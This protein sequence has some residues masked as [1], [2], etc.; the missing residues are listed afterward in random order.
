MIDLIFAFKDKVS[1]IESVFKVLIRKKN[2]PSFLG[3]FL[4]GIYSA[5]ASA[6]QR[7]FAQLNIQ[8][9]FFNFPI[10]ISEIILF[11][12]LIILFWQWKRDPPDFNKYYWLFFIFC[13]FFLGKAI[14]GYVTFG[15]LSFRNAALFYYTFFALLGYEFFKR[16]QPPSQTIITTILIILLGLKWIAGIHN[17][18]V[19]PYFCLCLILLFKIQERWIWL[20]VLPLILIRPEFENWGTTDSI[21]NAT[22]FFSGGGRARL[23]GH[24]LALVFLIFSLGEIL[25]NSKKKLKLPVIVVVLLVLFVVAF[26]IVDKNVVKS[27]TNF[28]EVAGGYQKLKKKIDNERAAFQQLTCPAR[29]Y[30]KEENSLEGEMANR[31]K[32][33]LPFVKNSEAEVIAVLKENVK[34]LKDKEA[35]EY[36][37]GLEKIEAERDKK[38]VELMEVATESDLAKLD[39][40]KVTEDSAPLKIKI[41][42]LR[43]KNNERLQNLSFTERDLESVIN[44]EK[45][46]KGPVQA[47]QS[48]LALDN[49]SV[50]EKKIKVEKNN[51]KP[52]SLTPQE[53]LNNLKKTIKKMDPDRKALVETKLETIQKE[54]FDNQQF[55]SEKKRKEALDEVDQLIK[56]VGKEGEVTI[57]KAWTLDEERANNQTSKL[58]GRDI[59]DAYNNTYFRLFIWED[60]IKELIHEKAWFGVNFGKPQRSKSIEILGWAT[61]EWM[62]DGWIT[63]HNSYIHILYRGGIV[64]I[65]FIIIVFGILLQLIRDFIAQRSIDGILLCTIFVYWFT[66]ANFLVFLEFPYNAIPFWTLFGMTLAYY[67]DQK[68]KIH[69]AN[70]Q[71]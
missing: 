52:A 65:I 60:M 50:E 53:T 24:L 25:L 18:Y 64:G 67:Q 43:Q 48:K 57:L 17:Y 44:K 14:Y 40:L 4:I 27:F 26:K 66:I 49:P 28:S 19:F 5:P 70:A 61:T 54:F 12:C 23:L 56:S 39:S 13:A 15:P 2:F 3:L 8:L 30:S 45:E 9:Q 20:L 38:I 46:K 37:K 11:F 47:A 29:L 42:E 51:Q 35:I 16:I 69:P 36:Y 71:A 33:F 68:K 62:L 1:K 41:Q 21:F 34:K 32:K 31:Y 59:D 6:F 55:L 58:E 7:V 63:P 10:F 22:F